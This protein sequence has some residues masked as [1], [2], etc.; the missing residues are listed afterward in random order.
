MWALQSK[1]CLFDKKSNNIKIRRQKLESGRVLL[2][3]NLSCIFPIGR[4]AA[5]VYNPAIIDVS[6]DEADRLIERLIQARKLLAV[7][8][9]G[10]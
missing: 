8:K 4:E 9:L 7:P 2:W 5:V 1:C 6:S 10:L 3:R